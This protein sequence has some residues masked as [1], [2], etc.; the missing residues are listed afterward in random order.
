MA[1]VKV[2]YDQEGNT[3]TVWFADLQDEHVC[4]ARQGSKLDQCPSR[5]RTMGEVWCAGKNRREVVD[6]SS[7]R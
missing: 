7:I 6:E 3:L 1:K 5:L 2:F 4:E